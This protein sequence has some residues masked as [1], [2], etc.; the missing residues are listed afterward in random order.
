MKAQLWPRQDGTYSAD[1]LFDNAPPGFEDHFD[2]SAFVKRLLRGAA[3]AEY[4]RPDLT[5]LCTRPDQAFVRYSTIEE[6]NICGHLVG[7]P[8]WGAS[9][10]T[11]SEGVRI[12]IKP[13]GPLKEAMVNDLIH[14]PTGYG[15]EMRILYTN[16]ED[17]DEQELNQI[18]TADFVQL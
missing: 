18:F 14:N 11:G 12:I 8:I 1:F 4:H 3:Y 5:H 6:R 10:S 9:P 7:E 16:G 15:L 17:S 2:Q 13:V